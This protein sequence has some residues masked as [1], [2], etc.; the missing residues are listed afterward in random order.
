MWTK[1]H[2]DHFK[3]QERQWE[4][5]KGRVWKAY[6]YDFRFHIDKKP[7]LSEKAIKILLT[8]PAKIIISLLSQILLYTSTK[9]TY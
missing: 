3:L 6:S 9:T 5:S 4:L 7:Q 2:F 1:D 8:F